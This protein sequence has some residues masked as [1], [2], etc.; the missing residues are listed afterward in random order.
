MKRT[1][2]G[3]YTPV[4]TVGETVS[5]FIPSPLPPKPPIVFDSEL[6]E[7]NDRA[8]LAVGRLD[9]AAAFLPDTHLFLYQYIRKEA[10]MSSQIEGTQSSLS[11]LMF[12]EMDDLPAVPMNDVQEVSRYV[13]AMEL[14]L[15]R[16]GEGFPLSLRLLRE[17]HGELLREGRGSERTPGEFRRSQNW[18]GGSRPGNA[19]HVPP[20][21]EKIIDCMGELELFLHDQK[22]RFNP[23]IKAALA[24]AQFETIHPFLDGNGRLG[25]LLIPLLL[26]HDGVLSEPL[27]YL[28]LYFKTNRNDYYALLQKIRTEGDWESWLMFFLEAVRA[29]AEQGVETA[30]NLNDMAREDRASIRGLGRVAGSVLRVH[31]ELLT[32]PVASV[33]FLSGRTG[34]VPNTIHKALREMER[35]GIVREGTGRSR[36]RL[37]VYQRCLGILQKGTEIDRSDVGL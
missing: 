15:Q 22:G 27:L 12:F 6:R 36:N 35:L 18:I 4:S 1:E 24:H 2:T 16:L 30:R 13:A 9:S 21:P 34:L 29:T 11:D 20:P 26:V 17:M 23:L 19:V 33:A 10:V 3:I 5:A 7:A 32:R 25:R 28:S 8:L 37:Y 31:Q 14:G